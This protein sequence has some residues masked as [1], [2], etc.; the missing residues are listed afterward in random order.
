MLVKIK[1]SRSDNPRTRPGWL[2]ADTDSRLQMRAG[3]AKVALRS[4][5][6]GAQ[7]VDCV[8]RP[9]RYA[10]QAARL[11]HKTLESWAHK[12]RVAYV[13]PEEEY[14]RNYDRIDWDA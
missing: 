10:N 6:T 14:Q 5:A 7:E 11:S 3:I 13:T 9:L 8:G 12:R 4:K 1:P 2:K